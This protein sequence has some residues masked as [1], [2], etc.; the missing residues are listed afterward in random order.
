[1][2]F[3]LFVVVLLY[4]TSAG[5]MINKGP[6][7][8]T[9]CLNGE[10]Q[11]LAIEIPCGFTGA[12]TNTTVPNWRIIRRAENGSV[13][14][15]VTRNTTD[16][17]NNSG[18]KLEWVPDLTNQDVNSSINS[19][20]LISSVD[21]T[22][23]QSSYQCSFQLDDHTIIKSKVGTITLVDAF[24]PPT[25]LMIDTNTST[26]T[27][28]LSSLPPSC[29]SSRYNATIS[30]SHGTIRMINNTF[31]TFTELTS[32]TSYN[33]TVRVVSLVSNGRP[34][35]V[36]VMTKASESAPVMSTSAIMTSSSTMVM[37]TRA[38]VMPSSTTGMSSSTAGMSSSTAGMSSST[39]GMSSSTAGM[40]SSTAGM[41]SST[42]G[43]SS[44]TAGMSS[45]TA[46]MSISTT[47]MSSSITG[48]SSSTT[49]ISRSTIRMSTSSM[50]T[51]TIGSGGNNDNDSSSSDGGNGG[52][53]GAVIGILMA[54]VVT[55]VV[56][57]IIVYWFCYHK[58]KDTVDY[59]KTTFQSISEGNTAEGTTTATK[60]YDLQSESLVN[61]QYTDIQKLHN[62]TATI[63]HQ[64]APNGDEYAL[65]TKT[66]N[67]DSVKQPKPTPLPME[68][69]IVDL[70]K[71]TTESPPQQLVT[72][73]D[74]IKDDDVDD[75]KPANQGLNYAVLEDIPTTENTFHLEKDLSSTYAQIA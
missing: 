4:S 9:K 5:L 47:G 27:V 28:S 3:V 61:E 24:D 37:S 73:Y 29:G 30:P 52:I 51:Q 31:I 63:P 59:K 10:K 40:S 26:I 49:G 6:N 25:I 69:A 23:N 68:C 33:I 62:K 66:T 55:G 20:L 57:I 38:I 67:D 21:E 34:T 50:V 56:I 7:N 70:Q 74:V 43:M 35:S 2:M 14:S 72:G 41:S 18:D 54:L 53:I 12:P 75:K 1:M 11:I 15:D 58:K 45:S 32:N 44:S 39:A 8:V 48:M 16:I 64:I 42:A 60:N 13:I 22:Y 17:N 65:P 19:T 71:K 36:T 46:G